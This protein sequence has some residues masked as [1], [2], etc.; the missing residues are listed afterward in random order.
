MR[1][2]IPFILGAAGVVLCDAWLK[3]VALGNFPP[4]TEVVSPGIVALVVHK[5]PGIAF[6][7]PL[8]IPVVLGISILLGMA[9]LWMAWA[10]RKEQGDVTAAALTVFIGG[11]G[12]LWDRA[13]FGFTVDYLLLFGRSALNA[14]D[15]VIIAGILWMLWAGKRELP[16]D[17]T[18]KTP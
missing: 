11:L 16:V 12:N 13:E 4:D 6:N 8:Q 10:H 15:F 7:I 5:N 1:A 18:Q 9:L 3:R 2:R 14:S 17:E